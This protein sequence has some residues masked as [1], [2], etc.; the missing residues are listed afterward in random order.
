MGSLIMINDDL[1][2]KL[3]AEFWKIRHYLTKYL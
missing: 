3:F 2:D 1:N